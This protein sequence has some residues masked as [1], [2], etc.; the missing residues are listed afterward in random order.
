VL[1]AE[2]ARQRCG[3]GHLIR[4]DRHRGVASWAGDRAAGDHAVAI[5]PP[6]SL[7]HVLCA[8]SWLRRSATGPVAA[9]QKAHSA[10]S[11]HAR[12]GN[13]TVPARP[14]GAC[15]VLFQ[16]RD[17]PRPIHLGHEPPCEPQ[18][19]AGTDNGRVKTPARMRPGGCDSFLARSAGQIWIGPLSRALELGFD[20]LRH[21]WMAW[22]AR[23]RSLRTGRVHPFDAPP[24][25]S[26]GLYGGRPLG[27]LE[28]GDGT[29]RVV[30]DADG[31][32]ASF[33]LLDGR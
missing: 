20:P 3:D 9:A 33:F 17:P 12:E 10:Q 31:W 1:C 22:P 30:L 19:I 28:R 6:L 25:H 13:G 32:I 24:A 16:P 27:R 7:D 29:V 4:P 11:R 5:G 15:P 26:R 23:F 18:P 2:R 14:F 21:A 8:R